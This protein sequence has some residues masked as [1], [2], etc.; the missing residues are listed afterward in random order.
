[1]RLEFSAGIAV[2]LER[3]ALEKYGSVKEWAIEFPQ[4]GLR[5]S[6]K[7]YCITD[8]LDV[9]RRAAADGRRHDPDPR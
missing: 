3:P 1:M 4:A 7:R 8:S 2:E 5:D 9:V 6:V